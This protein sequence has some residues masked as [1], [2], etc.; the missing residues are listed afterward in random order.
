MHS[1]E[2]ILP[3]K[4]IPAVLPNQAESASRWFAVYTCSRHEKMVA[5]YCAQ[6][7]IEY[8]LPLYRK[9]HHW[10]RHSSVTLELPLFP[11]YVFVH[12]P[13]RSRVPVLA[14]PGVLG[15]VGHGRISSALSDAEI[16]SL[17]A[18]LAEIKLE[19]HPYLVVGERVR[20][21]SGSLEGM[22]GILVRKKNELRVVITLD[23]IRQSVA[24]EVDADDVEPLVD[25]P[26]VPFLPAKAN[27]LFQ[28][29]GA[30]RIKN[31]AHIPR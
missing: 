19:P 28:P 25:R 16:E 21:R 18:A 22:Q 24:A 20:I 8:F 11:N 5:K 7:N 17:R 23:L 2:P 14:L 15:L 9:V 3:E 10:A 4:S 31:E 27:S 29:A 1:F 13:I 30:L 26:Y 12:I 6:R